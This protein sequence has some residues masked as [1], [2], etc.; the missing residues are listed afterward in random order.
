MHKPSDT[1][2][3]WVTRLGTSKVIVA[4]RVLLEVR[5]PTPVATCNSRGCDSFILTLPI[6]TASGR[7]IR[8]LIAA[9]ASPTV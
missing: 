2:R 5:V 6:K 4:L 3:Y 8:S 1:I 7:N 9:L